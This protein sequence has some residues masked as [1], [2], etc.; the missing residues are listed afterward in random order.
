ML[1]LETDR[2]PGTWFRIIASNWPEGTLKL[3]TK[4]ERV[5]RSVMEEMRVSI[6]QREASPSMVRLLRRGKKSDLSF[7]LVV[8]VRRSLCEK[9]SYFW[10]KSTSHKKSNL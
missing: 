9:A 4:I 5:A 3:W 8:E 2:W 6:K 10:I 7:T 1:Y